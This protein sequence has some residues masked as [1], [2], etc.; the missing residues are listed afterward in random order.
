MK[1]QG[2]AIAADRT[3]YRRVA[4]SVD[5]A[6][7][8]NDHVKDAHYQPIALPA[9]IAAAKIDQLGE[10]AGDAELPEKT[11]LGAIEGLACIASPEADEHLARIGNQEDA[12]EDLRKAAWRG[13]RRSRRRQAATQ[14]GD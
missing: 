7:A 9:L 11:R 1:K 4:Q 10:V 14:D 6:D 13:L 8:L 12:V 3:T 2:A 5:L